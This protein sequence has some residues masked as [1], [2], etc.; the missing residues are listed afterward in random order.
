MRLLKV[1]TAHR[2]TGKLCEW[3]GVQGTIEEFGSFAE[4]FEMQR[5][6]KWVCE[7]IAVC[8][9]WIDKKKPYTNQIDITNE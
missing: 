9:V 4:P 6:V 3:S 8:M 7:C 2:Y 1:F 5:C